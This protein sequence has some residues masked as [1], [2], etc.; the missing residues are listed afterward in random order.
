M[1]NFLSRRSG[2]NIRINSWKSEK[3]PRF[4]EWAECSYP[5]IDGCV[6][7]T[8]RGRKNLLNTGLLY[9]NVRVCTPA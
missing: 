1:R 5:T 4:I 2:Y 8:S 6:L 7:L 9:Y 3:K